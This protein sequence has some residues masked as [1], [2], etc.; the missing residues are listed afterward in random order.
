MQHPPTDGA[1]YSD[2]DANDPSNASQE[3]PT[4]TG[5]AGYER[6]RERERGGGGR[7]WGGGREG[8]HHDKGKESNEICGSLRSTKGLV[9][10][11]HMI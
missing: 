4:N 5:A 3:V 7:Q 10:P 9:L 8:K 6:E 2:I 11:M 1:S